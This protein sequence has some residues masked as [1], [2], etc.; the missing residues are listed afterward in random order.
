MEDELAQLTVVL[1]QMQPYVIWLEVL[2]VI[3]WSSVASW[4][5]EPLSDKR[6]DGQRTRRS[7]TRQTTRDPDKDLQLFLFV[8]YSL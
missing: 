5:A 3:T 4:Q 8:L 1:G 2:G 6:P 7:M